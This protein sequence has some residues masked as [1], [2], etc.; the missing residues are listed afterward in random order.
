MQVDHVPADAIAIEVAGKI[1]ATSPLHI[2]AIAAKVGVV[3]GFTVTST[4]CR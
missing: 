4:R 2:A 3:C 1:G